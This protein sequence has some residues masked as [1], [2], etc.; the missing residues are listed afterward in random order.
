[1]WE[2]GVDQGAQTD[3]AFLM[4][5]SIARGESSTYSDIDAVMVLDDG[6][7]RNRYENVMIKMDE[8]IFRSGLKDTGFRFCQGGLSPLDS[9][10]NPALLG[11][12]DYIIQMINDQL[13]TGGDGA[14]HLLGALHTKLIFGDRGLALRYQTA[15]KQRI[16]MNTARTKAQATREIGEFAQRMKNGAWKVPTGNEFF[17]E[18]KNQLYRPAHMI[19]HSLAQYYGIK[20]VSGREQIRALQEH[21]HMS[22]EVGNMLG[23][24]LDVAGQLRMELQLGVGKE[25]EALKLRPANNTD[26]QNDVNDLATQPVA[27]QSQRQ[28]VRDVLPTLRILCGLAEAF[29]ASKRKRGLVAR[30]NPFMSDRPGSFSI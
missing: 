22:L 8:L 30:E 28:K 13:A 29:A 7:S 5:G 12:S 3:F 20:A 27:T 17:I 2:S 23:Q 18:V 15:C 26:P 6:A 16:D 11:T 14:V 19:V 9:I 21:Q 4:C 25:H 10:N 24:L 1:L